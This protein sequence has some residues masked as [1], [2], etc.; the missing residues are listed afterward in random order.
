MKAL[1]DQIVM[2][3]GGSQGIGYAIA[4]RLGVQG[5][6]ISF[7]ARTEESLRKAESLL[8]QAGID[9]LAVQADV[10]QANDVERWFYLTEQDFG[11]VS[12]LINNA[13][14]SGKGPFL[15]LSESQWDKT[16]A[17]NCRGV[18]LCTQRALPA[19]TQAKQGRII[20][21][22]S[23]SSLYYRKGFSLYFASKWALN[24]F[25]HCLAKE[26]QEHNIHVHILC[27]GMVETR[28]FDSMGGRPHPPDYVY[29]EP[30]VY[31]EW[32]ERLC[33]LP[34]NLDTLEIAV[35]P[36]WQLDRFGV[37]R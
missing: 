33:M 35:L 36:S 15:E 25:A 10:S 13:G 31:A 16:M 29:A 28:F 4:H 14:I 17:V 7:C 12:I 22:S 30:E 9:C 23:I 32:V 26:V 5:A 21:V 18:F 3:S 6:K 34:D 20:M 27:P 1:C 11:P 24:G 19:M 8:G 37:R 2:I